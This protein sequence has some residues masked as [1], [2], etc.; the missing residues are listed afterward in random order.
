[1]SLQD[2]PLPP[3][4]PQIPDGP[5]IIASGGP[6]E[7]I[8][9]VA[10]LTLLFIIS[11]ILVYP[12]VR[13]WARRIEGKGQDPALLEEIGY[14]RERIAELEQSTARLHELEDRM[15]FTERMMTQQ[16]Q[17]ARLGDGS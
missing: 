15:D 5:V 11:G 16:G 12:L 10:V 4:P 13:A 2:A 6:P 3:I 7:W 14:L 1:M 9:P 8:A 17:R